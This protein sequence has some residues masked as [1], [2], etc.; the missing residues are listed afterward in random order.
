L[1]KLREAWVAALPAA[2]LWFAVTVIAPSASEETFSVAL[3]VP[4]EQVALALTVPAPTV[5]PRPFSLQVPETA[6]ELTLAPP[7]LLPSPGELI[8]TEGGFKSSVYAALAAEQAEV[9]PS[10]SV[11]FA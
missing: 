9:R 8:A 6:N 1:T 5:T 11:T 7:T 4:A 3:Q 10:G 2:S